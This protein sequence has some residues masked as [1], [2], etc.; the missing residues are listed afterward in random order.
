MIEFKYS[1]YVLNK[2]TVSVVDA[3]NIKKL[4]NINNNFAFLNETYSSRFQI[5]FF[6]FLG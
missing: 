4:E 6:K 2:Q 5:K 1:R 3:A